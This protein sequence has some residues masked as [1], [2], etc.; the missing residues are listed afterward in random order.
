MRHGVN[1]TP[2]YRAA[3][4]SRLLE[5]APRCQRLLTRFSGAMLA[6][7]GWAVPVGEK[8]DVRVLE[9]VMELR[10]Y[11]LDSNRPGPRW[12]GCGHDPVTKRG[13]LTVVRCPSAAP[14][15]ACRKESPFLKG[16]EKCGQVCC[17]LDR[18]KYHA[19]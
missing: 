10:G 11:H 18:E 2:K 7:L 3:K 1:V 9:K 6:R 12:Y 17:V 14:V 4:Q 8:I 16:A 5:T 15:P 13:I 19:L